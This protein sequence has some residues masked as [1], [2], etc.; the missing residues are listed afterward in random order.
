MTNKHKI[1]PAVLLV[2][3][4]S[5][6]GSFFVSPKHASAALTFPPDLPCDAQNRNPAGYHLAA[7]ETTPLTKDACK[8]GGWASFTHTFKNQ[9]QCVSYVQ[10][11][12]KAGK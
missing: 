11:N 3:A 10:A 7:S 8:N 5:L 9:G 1:L 6:F 12:P 2:F 4:F